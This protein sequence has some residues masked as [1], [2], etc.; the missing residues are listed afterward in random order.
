MAECTEDPAYFSSPVSVLYYA[1]QIGSARLFQTL[2]EKNIDPNE[3]GPD[4][5]TPLHNVSFDADPG[6]IKYLTGIYNIHA[7]TID[8][9]FPIMKV[10]S[11]P[12]L[13]QHVGIYK[14]ST[15]FSEMHLLLDD[16]IIETLHAEGN[17][18]W[19]YFCYTI[20]G[21][22]YTQIFDMQT[23][24]DV[25]GFFIDSQIFSSY[26]TRFHSS[27]VLPLLRVMLPVADFG[28]DG[29]G[30]VIA[31]VINATAY[32]EPIKS[33]ELL[34]SV[35]GAVIRGGNIAN[36]EYMLSKGVDI[37]AVCSYNGLTV[38]HTA[39]L[40]RFHNAAR[41]L[42][43]RGANVNAKD[44]NGR[45]PLDL[46]LDVG[47]IE[48]ARLLLAHESDIGLG[49]SWTKSQIIELVANTDEKSVKQK[50][51]LS[52]LLLESAIKSGDL[53]RCQEIAR[54]SGLNLRT[55]LVTS[56]NTCTLLIYAVAVSPS[57]GIL[58]WL[59]SK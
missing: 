35:L 6:F 48:I 27:A 8:G 25:V 32:L 23:I 1:A 38:L 46:A 41:V 17:D 24:C 56:C 52:R 53:K 37:N 16:Q 47:D 34:V 57:P 36:L 7:R 21:P 3:L 10:Y 29:V 28:D 51:M 59:L 43:N 15:I 14:N 31:F 58:Q 20:L 2:L 13:P 4:D 49:S 42:I 40:G 30:M 45:T 50:P 54:N 22:N 5:E 19:E 39:V 18:L 26:E 11:A 55:T 44:V 9:L 33:H 12:N